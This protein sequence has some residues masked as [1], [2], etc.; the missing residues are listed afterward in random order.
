MHF[1]INKPSPSNR[2]SQR[3]RPGF[4]VRNQRKR[5]SVKSWK[6]KLSLL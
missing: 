4:S 1:N 5:T 2:Q 3:L 6:N